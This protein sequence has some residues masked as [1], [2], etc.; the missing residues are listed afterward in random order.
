[1]AKMQPDRKW[2]SRFNTF[3][4][5]S[6]GCWVWKGGKNKT[7]YGVFTF[8]KHGRTGAHRASWVFHFGPIPDGLWVLHRCDNPPC[9]NPAHLFLGDHDANMA[10]KVAKGR[11][12]SMA[13]MNNPMWCNYGAAARG[14]EAPCVKLT[15][16]K[17]MEIR[18]RW[19]NGESQLAL[20]NEFNTPQANI[21]M[22]VRG[23]SWTHLPVIGRNN[24]RTRVSLGS[25]DVLDIRRLRLEGRTQQSLADEYGVSRTAIAR[26]VHGDWYK[27][28]EN[29]VVVNDGEAA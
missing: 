14:E 21:W 11:S 1:M 15:E 6:D 10:D 8:G 29:D 17:V 28:L 22:I 23:K 12:A 13:G 16:E 27:T 2:L 25:D 7:G 5:K 9:V 24:E 20:G 4:A 19:A 18:R 26:I 3:F